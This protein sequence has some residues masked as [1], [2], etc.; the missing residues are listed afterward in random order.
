[1][2]A[3]FPAIVPG[4]AEDEDAGFANRCGGSGEVLGGGEPFVG[5]GEDARSEVPVYEVL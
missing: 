1:M 2:T 4:A 3:C 5:E